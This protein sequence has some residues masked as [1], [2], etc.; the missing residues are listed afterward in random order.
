MAKTPVRDV[1]I[2]AKHIHGDGEL[3]ASLE[4]LRGG[5]TIDLIV[6]GVRGVWRK[7][8]D[9]K[10]GR[11]TPGIRPIGAA[12]TFWKDLY[13]SRRGDVVDVELAERGGMVIYPPLGRTE[14]EREAALQ[15]FLSFC[16]EGHSSDGRTMTRD[17]MHER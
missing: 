7:M 5:D 16:R 14:E 2:W 3:L 1:V 10:D 17:E 12:Q 13:A 8:A 15:R 9:G 4:A 11:R 6:D